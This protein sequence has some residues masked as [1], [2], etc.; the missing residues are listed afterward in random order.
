MKFMNSVT[1]VLILLELHPDAR[2]FRRVHFLQ[3]GLFGLREVTML[4]EDAGVGVLDAV[5]DGILVLSHK[6]YALGG[7]FVQL[8][9]NFLRPLSC[10]LLSIFGG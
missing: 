6:F 7:L 2:V 5:N 10:A 3:P 8:I 1:T 4:H 9:C